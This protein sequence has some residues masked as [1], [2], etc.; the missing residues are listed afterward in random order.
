MIGP[1]RLNRRPT[2]L[3]R[4]LERDRTI[5]V[6]GLITVIAI[7]WAYILTGAGMN[8]TASQMTQMPGPSAAMKMMGPVDWT[9]GYALLMVVMWWV[10]MTAMMLP[11]AAPMILVYA[12]INR[13]QQQD[14]DPI[15]ATGAFVTGYL[16]T[17]GGFSLAATGLQ[18]FLQ[19]SALLSAG[20]ASTSA[21]L[22]GV[23]LSAAGI[24]QLTPMKHVCLRYCRTPLHFLSLHWREGRIG[25]FRMGVG[26]GAFCLG[27]CWVLMGLLFYGGVMNLYW[28][29]GLAAFVLLEK[30]VPAGHRLS[31]IVGVGLI[32]WGAALIWAALTPV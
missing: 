21:L 12:A 20:M 16:M 5:V 13:K 18:W 10:M 4:L 30:L 22:G 25:A 1:P 24:W 9:P 32:G 26:H 28:I 3:E 19:R 17:W 23:L 29:I 14:G 27:C 7:S 31:L 15:I 2:A 11:S 6:V 8:M